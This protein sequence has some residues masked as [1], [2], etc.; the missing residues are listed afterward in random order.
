ML[1]EILHW[2]RLA[3]S[4]RIHNDLPFVRIYELV[5]YV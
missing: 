4:G 1:I 5:L 2:R 3:W